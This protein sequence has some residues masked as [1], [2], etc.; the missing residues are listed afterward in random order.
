MGHP[1]C[2]LVAGVGGFFP[3]ELAAKFV[4]LCFGVDA[5]HFKSGDLGE[6]LEVVDGEGLAE[7]GVVGTA[8]VDPGRAGGDFQAW[9]G[10]PDGAGYGEVGEGLRGVDDVDLV[11]DHAEAVA[12]VDE[13]GDDGR[14]GGSGEDEAGWV[15]FARRCRG[16]GLRTVGLP[17][18]MV[19][20]ISSMW[21]PRTFC[22]P[23]KS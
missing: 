21:E 17:A 6:V 13:R 9:F 4:D 11:D 3:E 23:V 15:G 10:E 18:A 12:H 5:D 2:G 22:G 14:A 8:R 19:G 1:G 16:G 7:A 20:Q